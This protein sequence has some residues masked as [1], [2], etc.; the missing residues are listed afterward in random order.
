MRAVSSP[1]RRLKGGVRQKRTPHG[2]TQFRERGADG[3]T[4]WK[5]CLKQTLSADRDGRNES[6]Q[7]ARSRH[8]REHEKFRHAD[9]GKH[10]NTGA[11]AD[12][13]SRG[14]R[15]KRAQHERAEGGKENRGADAGPDGRKDKAAGRAQR[16]QKQQIA[17]A[18]FGKP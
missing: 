11:Q 10:R 12:D 18:Q 9:G 4:F 3:C 7:C 5:R 1:V 16:P 13:F 8:R 2:Q 14:K 17:F 15:Q 6:K